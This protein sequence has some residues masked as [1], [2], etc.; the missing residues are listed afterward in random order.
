MQEPEHIRNCT[1]RASLSSFFSHGGLA[2]SPVVVFD[3]NMKLFECL[4]FPGLRTAPK[5]YTYTYQRRSTCTCT[6]VVHVHDMCNMYMYMTC[7]TCT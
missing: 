2:A 5:C 1:F 7:A 4:V 3:L 6:K